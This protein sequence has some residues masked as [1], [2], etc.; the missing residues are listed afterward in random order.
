GRSP[1]RDPPLRRSAPARQCPRLPGTRAPRPG[2]AGRPASWRGTPTAPSAD[3]LCLQ[4][5]LD[6]VAGLGPLPKPA[7]DALLVDLDRGGIRLRVVVTEHLEKA[8]IPGRA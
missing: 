7:A 6:R 1:C 5:P 2:R 3:P 4:Q 8:P